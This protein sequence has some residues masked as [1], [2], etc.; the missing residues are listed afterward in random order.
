MKSLKKLGLSLISI[1]AFSS[2]PLREFPAS[3][4]QYYS[5]Y[6]GSDAILTVHQSLDLSEKWLSNYEE[7]KKGLKPSFYRWIDL[8]LIWTL[9]AVIEEVV[10]HEVFGHGYR[11][12]SLKEA[13]VQSYKFETPP[14]FG[15]GG[16][17]TSFYVGENLKLGELQAIT[18][19]GLEAEDILARQ[20]KFSFCQ[21][22]QM[23][24]KLGILFA[25]TRLSPFFYSLVDYGIEETLEEKIFS[26]HDIQ[27]FININNML[28]PQK[29][30]TKNHVTYQLMLNLLDPMVWYQQYN[31]FYYIFTGK[32][33][34]CPMI[35]LG[36][37]LKLLPSLNVYLAPYGLDYSLEQ[38]VLYKERPIYF[39]VKT[40]PF[41]FN[42]AVGAGIEAKELFRKNDFSFG[43]KTHFWM[44]PNFLASWKM[45]DVLQ[46][47][48]PEGIDEKLLQKIYGAYIG[49][50]ANYHF[51][52]TNNKF[53][54]ECGAKSKGYIQGYPLGA[55]S[56]WRVGSNFSF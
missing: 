47:I 52:N 14:P 54:L 19:A 28:Y 48:R 21:K 12:R 6:M 8:S 37:N 1:A 34:S 23:D 33:I 55:S 49:V 53:Y 17:A 25:Q 2:E 24:A 4:D 29:L 30:I 31:Y 56:V 41:E 18:V 9:I 46:E 38:Y 43:A 45:G 20:I 16:G 39:Y 36:E 3:V 10:Q 42:R 15:P 22:N 51:K 26:G 7:P 44:Q 11:I 27:A 5:P 32:N 40:S 35:K 13:D 50:L